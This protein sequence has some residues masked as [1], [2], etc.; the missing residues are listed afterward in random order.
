MHMAHPYEQQRLIDTKSLIRRELDKMGTANRRLQGELYEKAKYMWE[1]LPQQIRTF[2]DAAALSAQLSE[3]THSKKQLDENGLREAVLEKMLKKPYFGRVDFRETGAETEKFYIGLAN[4]MDGHDY[5][6]VV[7]DWRAPVSTLFYENGI[8]KTAYESPSGTVEGEVVK[9]RQ[10]EIEEGELKLVID[11]EVKINDAILLNAL[12]GESSERMKT[13]VS[14]IQREQ[15]LV[16]RDSES[17]LLL[18]LGPAGS[19]KTSIAL[20][21]VAYLLYRDRKKLKSRN[22]LVFS[23]NDIFS[24][25]IAGVIPEL[26]EQ[27][28][29]TTT[30]AEMIQKYCG[31]PVTEM[32]EQVEFLATAADTPR[33]RVRKLG[34]RLKGSREFAR[35]VRSYIESYVPPFKDL[36][37]QGELLLC[38]GEL[39]AMY[40]GRFAHMRRLDR[41]EAIYAEI[42]RLIEPVRKRYC[43]AKKAELIGE[44]YA[45]GELHVEMKARRAFRDAAGVMLDRIRRATQVDFRELYREALLYAVHQSALFSEQDEK[46]LYNAS[47]RLPLNEKLKFEDGIGI[48]LVM[49]LFGAIPPVKAIKHVVIDE[50]QDYSPAQHEIFARV[51]AGCGL[52]LLGDTSQLVN[53][54]MGMD[55]GEEILEIYG[56]KSSGLRRLSKS[57]RSTSEITALA[58]AVLCRKEPTEYFERHGKPVRFVTAASEGEAVAVIGRMLTEA[59]A[60]SGA[61][62]VVTKTIAEARR[63]YQMCRRFVPGLIL[64]D[65]DKMAYERG[66]CVIPLALSKGMEFDRVIIADSAVYGPQDDRLLYVA[67]TRAMHELTVVGVKKQSPLIPKECYEHE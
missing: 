14:T 43:A 7:C 58:D 27:E 57:Y 52:T 53:T 25:Y 62:A 19:G 59:G 48:L 6:M 11:A 28:V 33:N 50:I 9:L 42:A 3:V 36:V 56:R 18:V 44:G 51:F 12:G 40:T 55:S 38:G 23:P 49:A 20:H 37:F 60:E 24:N 15:N 30:F 13:I 2:D 17:E 64:A 16:I 63:Y 10:Y 41:L 21:R 34:I 31:S 1:E 26:G 67:L 65:D 46:L 5:S 54:G 35:S 39:A 22:I 45:E 4:L 8:G 32:Y 66:R 61:T 29:M 47:K